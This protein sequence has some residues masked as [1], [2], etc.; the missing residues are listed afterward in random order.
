M[1]V[2]KLVRESWESII[3]YEISYLKKHKNS[4]IP[5]NRLI[6]YFGSETICS[7]YGCTIYSD[8]IATELI[9]KVFIDKSFCCN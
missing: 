9:K 1:E 7:I 4:S 5:T 3:D 8:A 6:E 2:S